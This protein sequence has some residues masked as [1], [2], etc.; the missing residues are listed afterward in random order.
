MSRRGRHRKPT[1]TK[2]NIQRAALITAGAA[3]PLG[4]ASAAMA[5]EITVVPG[6]TLSEIAIEKLGL[7]AWEP[8]Y[9]ENRAV[10][11][12]NP[13]LILPGQKLHFVGG[14]P[15][16]KA[17]VSTEVP[18]VEIPAQVA[19]APVDELEAQ[20]S[21]PVRPTAGPVT[22]GYGARGSSFHDGIDF[23]GAIGDVVVAADSGTVEKAT[24]SGGGYGNEVRIR[25]VD[26]SVSFYGHMDTIVVVVGE[27]VAAGQ[28]IGTVGNTGHVV[29]GPNGDGSHLHFGV[30]V[31]PGSINPANWLAD[32][33]VTL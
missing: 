12:E 5:D 31:G 16:P 22:S 19:Q 18:T 9:E 1:N 33:G 28:Q 29:A 17:P 2:R 4:L 11:G 21:G 14:L 3:A 8:F 20:S 6:D 25:H 10:V 27:Y 23:D 24:D 26:G 7:S 13:D 15:L 30:E 32:R